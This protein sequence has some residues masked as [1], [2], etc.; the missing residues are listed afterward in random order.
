[1]PLV[2]VREIYEKARQDGYAVGG[3]VTEH[4]YMAKAV[5]EAAEVARSPVIVF[6]W[7]KDIQSAGPGQLESIV[8]FQA[9]QASIP[10]AIMLDHGTSVE[11]CVSCMV[12][13]HSGVMIDVSHHPLQ[14]NIAI[15]KR[16]VEIARMLDVFVEGEVGTI[17]RTFEDVGEY[18]EPPKYTD[19]QEVSLY[20]KESGADA[21]AIS[22]G[23]ASGL[24]KDNPQ[25]DFQ[26]LDRIRELTDAYL[27]LH[28]GSGL[29]AEQVQKAIQGGI[30]GIRFATEMRLAFFDA[31]EAKRTELGY[32]FPDSRLILKDG[33][34][35]AKKLILTRMDQLGCTGK[36]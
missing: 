18:S 34:E 27:I 32:D 35:A 30:S 28:G 24:Y 2:T 11:S 26:R 1:M 22:I 5:I 4:L 9:H 12:H 16:V 10:V 17:S 20:A 29:P 3:F 31:M 13:G 33:A 15:T 14:E 23:S 8:R 7:E 21:I 36:A 25:L 19:P 6:L